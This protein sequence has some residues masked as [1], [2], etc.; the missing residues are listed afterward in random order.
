MISKKLFPII[1]FIHFFQ[2][3]SEKNLNYIFQLLAGF[4]KNVRI[5][6]LLRNLWLSWAE[7]IYSVSNSKKR[8]CCVRAVSALRTAQYVSAVESSGFEKNSWNL[9]NI[10]KTDPWRKYNKQ[11]VTKWYEI[12]EI[13][14]FDVSK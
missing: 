13:L 12:E 7:L 6:H 1:I 5:H 8:N 4:K 11:C 14:P 10:L 9:Q 3:V 2:Y